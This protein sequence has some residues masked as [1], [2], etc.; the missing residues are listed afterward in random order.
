[1]PAHRSID[2]FSSIPIS[3]DRSRPAHLEAHW[4]LI[5]CEIR[6]RNAH[7]IVV[8]LSRVLWGSCVSLWRASSRA[9]CLFWARAQR[10][11][12]TM[13]AQA[14]FQRKIECRIYFCLFLW[15][16]RRVQYLYRIDRFLPAF[17][18]SNLKVTW[19]RRA[20]NTPKLF[21]GQLFFLTV[22]RPDEVDSVVEF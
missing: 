21:W 18:T 16:R 8:S 2:H 10:A 19:R 3:V 15:P 5:G 12:R 9:F 20:W 14:P 1:M 11:R 6:V 13:R 7:N 4:T 22:S 17:K